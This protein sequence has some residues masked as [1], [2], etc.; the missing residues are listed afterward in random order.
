MAGVVGSGRLQGKVA[1]I[2][3][4]SSGLGRAGA[5]R[6]AA[7]GARVVASSNQQ[8]EGK[9]VVR[10]IEDQGG[11]AIFVH[12]DVTSPDDVQAL[13]AAAEQTYGAVHVL[14]ASAGV[15]PT[16]TAP[17]TSEDDWRLAIEVNLGGAFRLAKFGIPA[18]QRA[19]GGSIILTASELGLVGASRSAAYCAAKGGVVNLT[20]A[21]AI[22]CGP[23]GIRVNCLCPGP[24]E[25]PMLRDWLNAAPDPA[26]AERV[27]TTPVLLGRIGRPEEIAEAALHLA[28]DAS[29]YATGSV[30]V[31]DG[32]ATAWYGL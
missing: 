9:Q 29:S 21:L 31:V 8:D 15:M 24:I 1:V 5:I 23:L 17:E 27:Q 3:G 32:G 10:Q 22:D 30:T 28:S 13:I 25:T 19:G 20:R 11:A 14:Y 2:T 12:C 16:G 6:F 4:A 26:K 7:E 18:L